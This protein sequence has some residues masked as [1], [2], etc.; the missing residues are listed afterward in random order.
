MEDL[1]LLN[2]AFKWKPGGVGRV[3]GVVEIWLVVVWIVPKLN[4]IICT[5]RLQLLGHGRSQAAE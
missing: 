3:G 4:E 5:I 2:R 1:R